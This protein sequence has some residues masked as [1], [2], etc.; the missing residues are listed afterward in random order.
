[1]TQNMQS[2][3]Q[4]KGLSQSRSASEGDLRVPQGE[5]KKEPPPTEGGSNNEEQCSKRRAN[6]TGASDERGTFEYRVF[7]SLEG[8][9]REAHKAYTTFQGRSTVLMGQE[10]NIF[11][12]GKK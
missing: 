2:D 11:R 8:G 12:S 6:A 7:K 5:D 10:V 1:M 3:E 4:K 9:D